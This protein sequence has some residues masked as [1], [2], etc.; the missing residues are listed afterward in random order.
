[1]PET[2]EKILN[3]DV[4]YATKLRPAG[5]GIG[6][7]QTQTQTLTQPPW[8][9]RSYLPLRLLILKIQPCKI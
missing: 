5:Y 2:H 3:P 4:V 7:I 9:P 6:V 1:M 8:P